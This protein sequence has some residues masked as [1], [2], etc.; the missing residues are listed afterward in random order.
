MSLDAAD[1]DNDGDEDLILQSNY[2][3]RNDGCCGSNDVEKAWSSFSVYPKSG[4]GWNGFV[5]VHKQVIL[6]TI[7]NA[8]K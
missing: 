3:L 8:E 1:I 7:F 4:T 5:R 6:I 2:I